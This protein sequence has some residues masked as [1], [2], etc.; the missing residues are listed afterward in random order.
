MYA[1]TQLMT[2][3]TG[4]LAAN[5]PKHCL[6]SKRNM[7]VEHSNSNG[8]ETHHSPNKYKNLMTKK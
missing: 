4:E 1:L 5:Q 2:T 6:D 7:L 3:A 8:I